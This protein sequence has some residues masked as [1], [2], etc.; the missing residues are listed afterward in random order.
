MRVD[1]TTSIPSPLHEQGGASCTFSIREIYI[2]LYLNS[3]SWRSK[4]YIQRMV[5]MCL[6]CESQ[7]DAVTDLYT[8][9]CDDCN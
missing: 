3:L 6:L 1:G 2:Q 9:M 4:L 5:K 8:G 7:P